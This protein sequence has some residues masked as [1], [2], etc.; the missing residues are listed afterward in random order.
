MSHM[1]SDTQSTL[2]I[3][4]C[5]YFKEIFPS[6]LYLLHLF[7]VFSYLPT[8]VCLLPSDPWSK[9][10]RIKDILLFSRVFFNL[11]EPRFT[12]S[13]TRILQHQQPKC[14][15]EKLCS[16]YRWTVSLQSQAFY[17][18]NWGKESLKM[19]LWQLT[20]ILFN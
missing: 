7:R 17:Y 18:N 8:L 1:P 10:K 16:L 20:I 13:L 11:F 15:K 3:C 14:K 9:T 6:L 2:R 12:F 4:L 5:A 19:Q